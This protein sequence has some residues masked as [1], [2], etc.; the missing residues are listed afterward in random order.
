MVIHPEEVTEEEVDHPVADEEASLLAREG[1]HL[2][3]LCSLID[4]QESLSQGASKTPW[5]LKT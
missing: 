3:F 1:V 5:S 2:K 4:S